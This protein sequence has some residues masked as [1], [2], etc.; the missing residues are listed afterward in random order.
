MLRN[1]RRD[2]IGFN[3]W[4]RLVGIRS[5]HYWFT[6]LRP[7]LSN[8]F[9][10]KRVLAHLAN[11]DSTCIRGYFDLA[12]A[13]GIRGLSHHNWSRNRLHRLAVAVHLRLWNNRR[14]VIAGHKVSGK[15]AIE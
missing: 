7:P 15:T 9:S 12:M 11:R 14:H 3:S 5:V 8:R 2:G 10:I 13:G 1:A 4:W 6:T